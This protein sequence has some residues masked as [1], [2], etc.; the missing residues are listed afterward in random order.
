MRKQIYLN[1]LALLAVA[2]GGA[3]PATA[4]VYNASKVHMNTGTGS[5]S[6]YIYNLLGE[7]SSGY[8]IWGWIKSTSDY[9]YTYWKIDNGKDISYSL[10]S[11]SK[12]TIYS[13]S[14]DFNS[15][16]WRQ[17]GSDK[18]ECYL[19]KVNSQTSADFAYYSIGASIDSRFYVTASINA[20]VATATFDGSK[21]SQ[22]VT[23]SISGPTST[24]FK[25]VVVQA[26]YDGGSN[27][28]TVG[29][30]TAQSNTITPTA[31]WDKTTVRYKFTAYPQDNYKSVVSGGS[32][33]YTTGDY[34]LTPTGISCSIDQIPTAD[35]LKSSYNA[36]TATFNPSITWSSSDNMTKAFKEADI[37]YST[38][39][40]SSWIQAGSF[41]AANGTGTVSVAPGYTS[42]M[43]KLIE[44]PVD[45]LS[46]IS[47]F[48]PSYIAAEATAVSYDPAIK[49]VALSSDVTNGYDASNKTFSH[50]VKFAINSDLQMTMKSGEKATIDYSTDGGKS[51]SDATSVSFN[52]LSGDI[53]MTVPVAESY[54]YRLSVK[55]YVDGMTT[56]YNTPSEQYTVSDFYTEDGIGKY[57]KDAYQPAQQDEDGKYIIDNTGKLV[58]T[59]KKANSGE[60]ASDATI[61]ITK[62]ISVSDDDLITPTIESKSF[63]GTINGNGHT[64]TGIRKEDASVFG[65]NVTVNDLSVKGTLTITHQ[66]PAEVAIQTPEF[67][68]KANGTNKFDY[69]LETF[70]FED[71]ADAISMPIDQSSVEVKA[72]DYTRPS[73]YVKPYMSVCMPFDFT[74][75]ELPG[76]G[77]KVYKF[78]QFIQKGNVGYLQFIDA[79][80]TIPAG[81]P[82]IVKTDASSVDTD[83]A[84]KL[85]TDDYA[86]L[87][88]TPKESTEASAL[89]G[90][91]ETKVIGEGFYKLNDDGTNLTKTL[92]TSH[93]YPF[94]AYLGLASA[95]SVTAFAISFDDDPS[96]IDTVET[97]SADN[98]PVD[99]YDLA[100]NLVARQIL[101]SEASNTLSTGIYVAGGKLIIVK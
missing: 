59:I 16:R 56:I 62:D 101:I 10:K 53:T 95:E 77:S 31:P 35:E 47:G 11:F 99:V 45:E 68:A 81:T 13:I 52:D 97:D 23:Y 29:T 19:V 75:A 6:D 57:D 9:G 83:W 17:I 14:T 51:W 3:L 64:I 7:N 60:I 94:R 26:S 96:G 49:E 90:S 12:S 67:T 40:G 78:N 48:S 21:Y 34:A 28:T 50:D 44:K 88:L 89:F 30:Y 92:A 76:S 98:A 66:L 43:F 25:N 24:L 91:F 1:L 46:A 4:T 37:Y 41:T 82:V 65:G 69:S 80:G 42:Y 38:D 85:I 54:M 22:S 58:N 18:N 93:T 70:K 20:N 74:A 86:K 27:W 2:V 72:I 5:G 32:W 33:T 39:K 71:L 87:T 73:N 55:S 15:L 63:A 84:F 36:A 100:G 8:Q 61:E 79:T